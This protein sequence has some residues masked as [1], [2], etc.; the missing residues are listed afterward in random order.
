MTPHSPTHYANLFCLLR[1]W[2]LLS[3]WAVWNLHK[4]TALKSNILILY[5]LTPW[6][7]VLPEQLTGLQLVKKFPAFHGTRRFIT[8]LTSVRLLR[9][10][11]PGTLPP[12]EPNGG[13][14]YLR[15]VLSPEQ[16]SHLWMFLNNVFYREGLLAPH[17]TPKLEDQPSSAVRDCLFNLFAATL[18]IRGRSSIRNLRTRNAVVTGTN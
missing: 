11:S 17:P 13:V 10:A 3:M 9:D 1:L 2:L 8:A 15:I 4:P 7:R 12:G 5:L 18:L 6:C 16:A 14:V